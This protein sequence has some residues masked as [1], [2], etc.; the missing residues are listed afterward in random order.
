MKEIVRRMLLVLSVAAITAVM[1]A[2][3]A[4]PALAS[5]GLSSL[6]PGAGTA[7]SHLPEQIFTIASPQN[8]AIDVTPLPSPCVTFS[9]PGNPSYVETF[10]SGC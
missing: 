4:V 7:A 9:P 5:A 1:V 3:S 10:P 8:P 2:A 6:P